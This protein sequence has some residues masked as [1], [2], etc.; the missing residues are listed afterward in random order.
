MFFPEKLLKSRIAKISKDG[1][2]YF[3]LEYWYE[4]ADQKLLD[5][6]KKYKIVQYLQESFSQPIQGGRFLFKN[7]TPLFSYNQ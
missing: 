7:I 4:F 3:T 1:E 2:E 5:R 6:F